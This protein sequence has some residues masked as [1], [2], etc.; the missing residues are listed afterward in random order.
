MMNTEK[1]N[2]NNIPTIE[3]ID[4]VRLFNKIN[5]KYNNRKD[6]RKDNNKENNFKKY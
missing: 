1:S 4:T 5:N 2:I 3:Q 6:D